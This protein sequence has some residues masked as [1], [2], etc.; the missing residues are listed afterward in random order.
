MHYILIYKKYIYAYMQLLN[1]K[2]LLALLYVKIITHK[3]NHE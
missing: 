2:V 3:T 1:Q